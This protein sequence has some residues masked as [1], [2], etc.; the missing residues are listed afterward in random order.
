MEVLE[1]ERRD[2]LNEIMNNKSLNKHERRAAL[3]EVKERY[4]DLAENI[5][6]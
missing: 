1:Q 6:S 3:E 4:A 2:E 5:L